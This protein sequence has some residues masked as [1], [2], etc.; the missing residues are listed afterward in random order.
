MPKQ[1]HSTIERPRWATIDVAADHLHV[2]A[3]TIR[4]MISSGHISGYRFGSRTLRV[5]LNELD[6]IGRRIPTAAVGGGG[7]V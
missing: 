5:D 6:A 3:K 7:H 2:S 1:N 4:R